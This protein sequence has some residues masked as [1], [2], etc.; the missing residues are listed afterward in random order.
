MD[1]DVQV[2]SAG[3]EEHAV[4]LGIW[5]RSVAATHHFLTGDDIDFYESAVSGYLPAMQD[6]RVAD[7]P[8]HGP[9]GFIAQKDGEIHMLFVDPSA[10]G[11][12]IGTRLL[13]DIGRRFDVL[14]VDVNEDN[15]SGRH[16]YEAK[17][18]ERIGRSELDGEGRPFPLLHLRRTG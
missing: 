16:F 14:H 10:Q 1:F 8:G 4:L 2:R 11:R 13:D 9:L 3:P 5:R 15:D 12:G 7:Q 17:G 18:F 6:L